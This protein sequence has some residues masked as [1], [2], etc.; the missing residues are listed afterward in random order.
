MKTTKIS[1]VLLVFA[2]SLIC[3]QLAE[4]Q[5]TIRSSTFGNG[6]GV[7]E[8]GDRRIIGTL[9]QTLIGV[10][11]SP[12]NF[13]FAGF[14]YTAGPPP[15]A[16]AIEL[17]SPN[18]GEVWCSG[19]QYAVNWVTT[20]VAIARV[21]LQYST[22]GGVDYQDI[23]TYPHLPNTGT[24]QWTVPQV[25]STTVLVKAIAKDAGDNPLVEDVSNANFTI[26]M[27][28]IGASPASFTFNGTL[29]GAN[30]GPKTLS[31]TNPGCGTLNW[32]ATDNAT[33][34]FLSSASGST[35]TETDE[36]TV[37]VNITGLTEGTYN[38]DITIT[39]TNASNSPQNVPVT[40]NLY[41]GEPFQRELGTGWH[42]ISLPLDPPNPDPGVVLS[43]LFGLYNS[44]WAYDPVAGW[45][46]FVPGQASDLDELVPGE[47]YFIKMNL[48]GTMIIQGTVIEDTEVPLTGSAWNLV[49][50]SA[51]E[52]RDIEDCM[53]NVED[54]INLVWEYDPGTGWPIYVPDGPSDLEV[55]RPGYGYWIRADQTCTWDINAP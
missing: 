6:G 30:P 18:G 26:Q 50:Y 37:S 31:I 51:L 44:V 22:N 46:T 34:L 55:M 5:N 16:P 41:T 32:T 12:S 35:T 17:T 1:F 36:V 10:S 53:S 39:S 47:G 11:G 19:S 25:S 21:H 9:G 4:A 52:S 43:S 28:Q 20:G 24:Y 40:L 48:P 42:F 29:G 2:I 14:W 15:P 13:M 3:H 49:G 45:S 23:T 38:E 27:P 7:M 33:W 8:D 54:H